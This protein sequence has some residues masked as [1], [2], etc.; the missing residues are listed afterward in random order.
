MRDLWLRR[1]RWRV[2][3]SIP[4]QQLT[5]V[6]ATAA[7]TGEQRRFLLPCE[8]SAA[9]RPPRVRRVAQRE[10]LA[11]TAGLVSHTRLAFTP[12]AAVAAR[13]TLH[14]YQLEPAL[15]WLAGRR[16][17]LVADVVGLGKTIQAGL[18][19]ASAIERSRDARVLVLTPASLV[20]QWRDELTARFGVD[21]RVADGQSL[22]Q[23]RA[24][25]PYLTSPWLLPGVW[26]ATP[27]FLKQPHVAETL[28]G[29]PW[30]ILVA[31]E[32]HQLSG[33]SQRHEAIDAVARQAHTVVLLTATPHDGDTTR[34]DRL[35]RIGQR[36][37]ADS[38]TTFRRVERPPSQGRR[39]RWV[40][41]GLTP[42]DR[43]ALA[44][45]DHF[46]RRHR[47]ATASSGLSLLCSV[48]RRRALSSPAA[49][50]ASVARRRQILAAP[51][52]TSERQPT[53]FDLDLFDE[54]DA[55]G[56]EVNTN[57][58]ARS[59]HAWLSRLEYLSLRTALGGREAA[60]RTLL[61]RRQEPA[62]VFTHY[63]DT[64]T[65]IS[66][67]H[68]GRR[69]VC[70]HG[71]MARSE[72]VATLATFL[73]GEADTLFATDV[74]SQGL[75][76]QSRARWVISYEVPVTPLRLEQR[77]GRVDRLG[78]ER[79]VHATLLASRHATDV[80]QRDRLAERGVRSESADLKSCRRWTTVAASLAN[81]F[82]RQR[83][84]RRC[85]QTTEIPGP[86]DVTLEQ[87]TYSRL[88][89]CAP[90]DTVIS[91]AT[92]DADS[93]E[94]LERRLMVTPGAQGEADARAALE[95]RALTLR[96][97]LVTRAQRAA[98]L[99]A[100][101]TT[102]AHQPGLFAAEPAP[103]HVRPPAPAPAAVR[104]EVSPAVRIRIA[105]PRS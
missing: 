4:G 68:T 69:V 77:I 83:R 8:P 91:Q 81:W 34:F 90:A 57:V 23:L 103:A 24:R 27:D 13:I 84:L 10:A 38:L 63:R 30:D 7:D 58:P 78:Q 49:L 71:G 16:R 75:N 21:A 72:I 65:A 55:A 43:Q 99:A 14:A 33:A 105:G 82:E 73:S 9:A 39:T 60:L 41:V 93:G 67:G 2:D 50:R 101:A 44:A 54:E 51:D 62:V 98:R 1:R 42:A 102:P 37:A 59:E 94:R 76:L 85:W 40:R 45:I 104:V 87:P 19:I 66:L 32:A 6:H 15:A 47:G 79:P 20:H 88:F 46:E 80:A 18:I 95:R 70:L 86:V 26:L 56:L 96:A 100:P 29:T 36:H 17:L 89:D 35:C 28:P 64:L 97:R 3:Q 48:F 25:L 11:R 52:T 12:S 74:A 53:L 5:A 92:I 61:R 22:A 31:D